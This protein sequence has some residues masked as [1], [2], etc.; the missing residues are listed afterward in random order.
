[1]D[2]LVLQGGWEVEG[3]RK[4]G[5]LLSD[6]KMLHFKENRHWA[7]N[8]R[9]FQL[10]ALDATRNP[11]AIDFYDGKSPVSKGIYEIKGSQ[12]MLCT[13][14]PGQPRPLKFE[15]ANGTVLTKLQKKSPY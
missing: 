15:A 6:A 1:M 7:G 14:S 4:P 10:F 3:S 11:K 12:L 13:A 8:D 9:S 2:Y 5:Q